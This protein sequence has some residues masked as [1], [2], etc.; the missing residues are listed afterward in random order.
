VA[1]QDG[2]GRRAKGGRV[3][4]SCLASL[5]WQVKGE[6]WQLFWRE[7]QGWQ[8]KTVLAGGPRVAE[9]ASLVWQVLFGELK[10]KI[11]DYSGGRTKGGRAIQFWRE[12]QG[13]QIRVRKRKGSTY[14]QKQ[15]RMEESISQ[16]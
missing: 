13:R 2:S 1:G 10:E 6:D 16:T 7:D 12:G 4:K 8:S 5:V 15:G 14:I 9:L 11:G 3:G